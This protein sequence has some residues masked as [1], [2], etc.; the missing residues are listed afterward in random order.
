MLSQG[1]RRRDDN[2]I[3]IFPRGTVLHNH[4]GFQMISY[5]ERPSASSSQHIRGSVAAQRCEIALSQLERGRTR[6]LCRETTSRHFTT[7][8]PSMSAKHSSYVEKCRAAHPCNEAAVYQRGATM[9]RN[10]TAILIPSAAEASAPPSSPPSARRSGRWPRAAG[11]RIALTW[12][13]MIL[14]R[15][16]PVVWAVMPD[17]A[18]VVVCL[19]CGCSALAVRIA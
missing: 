15:I 7:N 11:L 3:K 16:L 12:T 14:Q 9:P 18:V 1:D 8:L 5:C 13:A 4:L 19:A 10:L 6:S 17:K 2:S